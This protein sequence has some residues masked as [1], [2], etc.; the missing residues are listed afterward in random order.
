MSTRT[1]ALIAAVILLSGAWY[2]K[3][4]KNLFHPPMQD[5][6]LICARPEC[7]NEF[8]ARIPVSFNKWPVACPKCDQKSGYPA[9]TCPECEQKYPFIASSP[10]ENCPKCDAVLPH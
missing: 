3:R 4:G 8:T 6:V 7:M 5:A 9:L 10:L 1:I 2:L